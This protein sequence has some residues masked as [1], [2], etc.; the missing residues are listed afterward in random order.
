MCGVHILGKTRQ[1][2]PALIA[3]C[4]SLDGG[5]MKK[6]KNVETG[7]KL[8][9]IQQVRREINGVWHKKTKEKWM[10]RK[11]GRQKNQPQSL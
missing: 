9:N 4:F 10:K 7:Q 1:G 3:E 6:K 11:E 5:E 2:Q 8:K